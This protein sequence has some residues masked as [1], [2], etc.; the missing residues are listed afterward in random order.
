MLCA[1]QLAF[2][3]YPFIS[4]M[5]ALLIVEFVMHKPCFEVCIIATCPLFVLAYECM[6]LCGRTYIIKL[7][8]DYLNL[9]SMR[10]SPIYFI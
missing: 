3:V 8:Y 2:L 5:L 4:Y 9:Q 7:K 10:E 6:S 1:K